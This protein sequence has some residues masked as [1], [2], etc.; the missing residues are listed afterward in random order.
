MLYTMTLNPAVDYYLSTP[1]LKVGSINRC[2]ETEIRFGGKG[3][4]VSLVLQSLG[5]PSTALGIIGGFTG[6]ALE[7]YLQGLG[8]PTDFVEVEG[9]TRINVKL[10][11]SQTELNA[12]APPITEEQWL[13]LKKKLSLLHHE[14]ILVLAG[15][16]P[17]SLPPTAYGELCEY[18]SRRGVRVV[19]DSSGKALAHAIDH[20]PFLLKPNHHELGEYFGTHI[21]DPE[22]AIPY[23][24]KLQRLGVK[25]V[26]VSFGEK[27]A[28]LL[29]EGHHLHIQTP[30]SCKTITSTVGAGDSLLGGFLAKYEETRDYRESLLFGVAVGTASV[31]GVGIPTLSQINAYLALFRDDEDSKKFL[32]KA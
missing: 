31:L 9:N 19:V 27:G 1:T 4:N 16:L 2:T 32:S 13:T 6:K 20:T 18:A 22:S 12:D 30:I 11:N 21:T 28:M 29:D 25:N 5:V 17:S 3:I 15:S 14:D 23:A 8:I 24:Q 7:G 26:L 10:K